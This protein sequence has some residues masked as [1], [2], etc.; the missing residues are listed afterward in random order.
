LFPV[1]ASCFPSFARPD[2]SI[3]ASIRTSI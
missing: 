2:T 1:R 3:R